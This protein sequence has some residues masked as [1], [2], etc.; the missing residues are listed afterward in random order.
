MMKI[1][2]CCVKTKESIERERLLTVLNGMQA[3]QVLFSKAGIVV[4]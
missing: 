1:C 2:A 3:L 4:N